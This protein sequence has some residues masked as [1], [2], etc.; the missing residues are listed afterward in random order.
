MLLLSSWRNYS[1]LKQVSASLIG[2][3]LHLSIGICQG[4]SAVLIPQLQN[5]N[6]E[7]QINSEDAS[8]I[9]S[10]GV[11]AMPIFAV[12][13]GI[14]MEAIGRKRSIQISFLPLTVGWAIIALAPSVVMICIGRFITGCAIAMDS[15][16][17]IYIAEINVPKIRATLLSLVG[18]TVLIGI[19]TS[20]LLG[21]FIYWRTAAAI[22]SILSALCFFTFFI[23]PESPVWLISGDKVD[24]ATESLKWLRNNELATV[25][26]ELDELLKAKLSNNQNETEE[27]F[28]RTIIRTK[29]WKP[30]LILTCYFFLQQLC[31]AHIIV[32][33]AVSF[34]N[35]FGTK[36]DGFSSSLVYILI[37]LFFG[38]V[39]TCIIEHTGRKTL[40]I[41]SSAGMCLSYL[42]AAVYQYL[43]QNSPG[44]PMNWFPLVCIWISVGFA[45]IGMNMLPWMMAGEL[46]PTRVRGVMAGFLWLTVYIYIFLCVKLYP[47]VVSIVEIHGV[48]MIFSVSG[49]VAIFLGKFFVP[50]TKGMSLIEIESLW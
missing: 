24:E 44:N 31:G 42:S 9:A 40:T 16:V 20:Y 10:V 50:E 6:S 38:I 22:L 17:V 5:S 48:L 37:S 33:Y 29:A 12:L 23:I 30:F 18:P 45:M 41:V 7:L 4:F 13:V 21:H 14:L 3:L 27:S 11:A 34:S 25:N 1:I 2:L 43:W 39:F 15:A 19:L 28:I 8:W 35:A 26:A 36:I 49:F 32:Y 46:F 47:L